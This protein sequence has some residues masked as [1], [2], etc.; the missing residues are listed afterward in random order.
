VRY[1]AVVDLRLPERYDR[2][3]KRSAGPPGAGAV[4][5][6]PPPAGTPPPRPAAHTAA[7]RRPPA[8]GDAA[9]AALLGLAHCSVDTRR[10]AGDAIRGQD[11]SPTLMTIRHARPAC[12]HETRGGRGRGRLPATRSA[13]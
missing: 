6:P 12:V 9:G 13:A 11:Y 7:Q 3:G 4:W 2:S 5:E 8:P 1:G 10:C